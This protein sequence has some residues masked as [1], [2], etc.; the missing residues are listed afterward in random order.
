LSEAIH[1]VSQLDA[2]SGEEVADE[3]AGVRS[4]EPTNQKWP[5]N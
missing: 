4:A 3:S 5:I 2:S 1:I